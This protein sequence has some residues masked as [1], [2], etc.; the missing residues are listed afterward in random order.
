MVHV[1]SRVTQFDK[2][3]VSGWCRLTDPI[4]IPKND[5]GQ[6]PNWQEFEN[7]VVNNAKK[8]WQE[9]QE[10][11]AFKTIVHQVHRN[12]TDMMQTALTMVVFGST[13]NSVVSNGDHDGFVSPRFEASPTDT[14]H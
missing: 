8:A 13:C 5:L 2:A 6:K 9:N 11:S 7:L 12:L 10:K 4:K 3:P 1:S 14:V